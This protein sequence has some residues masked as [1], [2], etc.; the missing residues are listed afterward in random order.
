VTDHETPLASETEK[1]DDDKYNEMEEALRAA[2]L[3]FDTVMDG[4]QSRVPKN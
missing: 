3:R 4:S 2:T 1:T